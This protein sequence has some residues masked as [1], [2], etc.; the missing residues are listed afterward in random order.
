[1]L[2]SELILP[3]LKKRGNQVIPLALPQDYHYLKIANDLILF[4]K[5]H[6]GRSRGELEDGLRAYEGESLDYRI[7][8][9]LANVLV[10]RC[11]FGHDP[12]VNPVE[13]RMALFNQGPVTVKSDL[14]TVTTREQAVAETAT[15]F[16]IS[17][18]EV[19]QALFADL[20]EERILLSTGQIMTPV[21]L[22]ARYNLEVA[23]GLFY[24][25]REVDIIVRDGYKDLFKYI[26]LFKL[27]HTVYAIPEHGYNVILHGP[28]SPFVNST[29]RYGLQFAKFIPALLLCKSWR[30]DAEVHLP[31]T[32]ALHY[33]LDDRTPLR[34]HFKAS[35]LFDSRLEA[36]FASEFE[37]KYGGAK[38]KWELA[39]ED[40]LIVVSDTVMIP[41]FSLT[42]RKDGRRALIEIIGFWHPQY[43]QR[44]LRKIREAGRRDLI[45]LV[46]ESA[47]VAQGVFEEISAGEVLTFRKKPVL[48]DVLAAVERCAV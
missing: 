8:R 47:N 20:L 44:K 45:L 41:D 42:H 34:S 10:S 24:W 27:M 2:K 4:V 11:V 35:N 32:K 26:K 28:I 17:P 37:E 39:R 19:E 48:K 25:T 30:M 22:I 43:L 38:R 31:E 7:I 18:K 33:T 12:P 6:I 5:A 13:L 1:M 15:K 40:E 46:Y 14:L 9:G 23:R 29:I 36:D 3:R 16:G 21:D